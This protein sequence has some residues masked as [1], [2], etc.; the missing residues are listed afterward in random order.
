M[1]EQL[2]KGLGRGGRGAAILQALQKAQRQPGQTASSAP[3]V[4]ES[5]Q[6][7]G[8]SP[9]PEKPLGRGSSQLLA[10]L[11]RQHQ[12]Q[13]SG[14]LSRPGSSDTSEVSHSSE[15]SQSKISVAR[16]R[17]ALLK[18]KQIGELTLQPGNKPMSDGSS[19]N[20][21]E[22]SLT[23]SMQMLKVSEPLER[24]PII[25]KG[26]AGKPFQACSN[27]IQLS[28]VSNKAMYEYEVKFDPQI[29]AKNVRFRLLNSQAEALGSVKSFDGVK[30]WLPIRLQREITVLNAEHPLT[31]EAVL[32]K[33]IYKKCTE[34]DQCLHLYNV[35]FSRIMRILKMARVGRNYYS[36]GGSIMVPQH[37]LE[38]WPGYV[39]A[40]QNMEGGVMLCV[41]VSHRVL[42]TQTVYEVL[43]D[44]CSAHRAGFKE[45]ALNALIGSCVL[46]R[47]NNKSYRI[48]DIL[49]DQNA[50]STFTTPKGE[51]S[52]LQY[53]KESYNIT[54]QDPHQPLLLN[55]IK[56]V[57]IQDISTPKFLCLV[58]ELC[59][60]TGLTDEMRSDFR[61]MKDL[62]QHTQMTPSARQ[63]SLRSFVKNVNGNEEACKVL[64]DWGLILEDTSLEL[65]GR[66]LPP[67][68]ILFGSREIHGGQGADWSREA[69]KERVIKPVDLEARRWLVMF[70]QRD[71]QRSY[72]FVDMMYQVTRSMGMQVGE[73]NMIR[74][75]DDRIET[76]VSALKQH[77]HRNLQM[78]VI[79]FPTQREDRY[80]A[81]KKLACAELS[82]PTQ[83]INSRTIGQENRL[84]SVV[85]KIALQI[86]CKLG[87]ELWALKIPL[88][89]LM[90]C[91][92]DVYHDPVRRGASV[93]GFVSSMNPTL[94]QWFSNT[95]FQNPGEEIVN[96]LK[97]SMLESLRHY[98]RIHHALPR[99]IVIY[100]DGVSDGQLH[101][102]EE[103]EVPQLATIFQD[104]DAYEPKMS[105]VVVQKRI[106]T[107]IFASL[108]GRDLSNP[109]PGSVVDYAITKRNWYDFLLVSQHVR[110]GT[111]SP[112]H[113]V[114]V[115]DGGHLKVDHMQ[116]LTYKLTHLYYNWPGTIRVPAPCQYAHKLAYLIG[117]N[118]KKA[119]APGLCDKLF[120]L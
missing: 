100:R 58:P 84:R 108:N 56:K 88:S 115:L 10:R 107:K 74:L 106:N 70:S 120:F 64:S 89:G 82:L 9:T 103:H 1:A 51:I 37:K 119:A 81:V 13:S 40:A 47:Y 36:P 43:K 17:G 91:G 97:I 21:R 20:L 117:Q 87:G 24:P 63:A 2:P 52:Y 5:S 94:T 68:N 86:N 112:T 18:A 109:G 65:E 80:S 41:D 30:L 75:A 48:D 45:A 85:Q 73:P 98:H 118:V 114:V 15:E 60:M 32:I 96:G 93:V 102:T 53:Y 7:A 78:A 46:T 105:F 116:R 55:K 77:Y 101:L 59:Y 69:G 67:E 61:V 27:W 76:Y 28:R 12:L 113:Y 4:I 57:E 3:I 95:S 62:A 39:T 110:Q 104:F 49:F 23:E 50:L 11:V 16:G 71:E 54:I 90:V 26:T 72:K 92:I 22:T 38:I 8:V 42:R 79:I 25:K 33:V 99:C 111:V 44:L 19:D 31:H 6:P 35:L 34:M 29:D 83:C 14:S 66:L